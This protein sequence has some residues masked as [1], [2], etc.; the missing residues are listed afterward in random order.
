VVL[1]IRSLIVRNRAAGLPEQEVFRWINGLP[2]ILSSP[3]KVTQVLG[4][5]VIGQIVAIAPP[6]FRKWRLALAAVIVTLGKLALERT[7]WHFVQ[8][9]RPATTIPGANARGSTPTTGLAFVFPTG[10]A[11]VL[12]PYG[13]GWWRFLLWTTVALV[14]FAR[15]YLEA[16]GPLDIIDGI[17]LGLFVGGVAN[18]IVGG[19]NRDPPRRTSGGPRR[20]KGSFEPCP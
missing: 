15:L 5:L 14:S 6:A 13:G 18:L 12:T 11:W 4:V 7:V 1:L 19:R 10:L 16:H 2:E 8:R 20:V 9:A 3:M 17:G